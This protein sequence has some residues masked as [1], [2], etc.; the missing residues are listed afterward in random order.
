MK[1][2]KSSLQFKMIN[3]DSMAS[4]RI[5]LLNLLAQ[6][7]PWTSSITAKLFRFRRHELIPNIWEFSMLGFS[8][9]LLL[10]PFISPVNDISF[11]PRQIFFSSRFSFFPYSHFLCASEMTG[12]PGSGPKVVTKRKHRSSYFSPRVWVVST[13]ATF[14]S[15]ASPTRRFCDTNRNLTD[16]NSNE[17]ARQGKGTKRG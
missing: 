6:P 14:D 4:K 3:N 15:T 13:R 2:P 1:K 17:K 7:S 5:I 11:I 12:A 9:K 8:Q 10:F 16:P